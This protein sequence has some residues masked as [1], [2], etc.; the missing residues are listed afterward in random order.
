MGSL[1]RSATYYILWKKF[2]KQIKVLIISA[3]ILFVISFI[4]QDLFN[5]LKINDKDMLLPLALTKWSLVLIVI[6]FNIY[7]FKNIKVEIEEKEKKKIY[8]DISQNTIDKKEI[9]TTTDLI[10][11]KYKQ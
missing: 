3:L 10:L 6:V 4:Y 9:L 7:Y 5:L 8:P 11:K 1:V 2:Q